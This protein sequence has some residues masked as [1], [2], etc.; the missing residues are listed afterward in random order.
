MFS[1][2]FQTGYCKKEFLPNHRGFDSFFGQWS[3][4]VD[5][6]N[7][8]TPVK[9][10][11]KR[12]GKQKSKLLSEISLHSLLIIK[13][14]SWER[15]YS[16][17]W[18]KGMIRSPLQWR[19]LPQIQRCLFSLQCTVYTMGGTWDTFRVGPGWISRLSDVQLN[20]KNALTPYA[21][22]TG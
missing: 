8:I 6:Y 14:A 1:L 12:K 15:V 16:S 21:P 17:S 2:L 7:R 18:P 10:T 3:H 22:C 5:Y 13:S 19:D 4:A 9:E 20:P 11:K